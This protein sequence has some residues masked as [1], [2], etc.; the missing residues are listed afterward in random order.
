MSREPLVIAVDLGGTRIRAALSNLEG[1]F[2]RRLEWSTEAER[3]RDAALERIVALIQEV[4]GD[5][6]HGELL[7]VGVGTPGPLD[8]R[9]GLVLSAPNM[10]GWNDLPLRT[11]LEQQIGLPVRLVNDANGAVLGEWLFGAGRGRQNLIYVT[12]STG[13]GGGVITDGHLL[14]GHCGLAGE[15]G[16]MTLQADGPRCNCGNYGCWEALASGTAIAR[17]GAAAARD[18]RSPLLAELCQGQPEQVDARMVGQAARQGDPVA[19]QIVKQAA[20]YCGVGLVNLLHLYSPEIILVGGGVSKMGD[21]LFQPMCRI[22]RKQAMPAYRGVP[23]EPAS[24]G[25]DMGLLG[26]VA[27]FRLEE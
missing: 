16:H 6:P 14:L 11:I 3:G 19:G 17:E 9:A 27:L 13:I 4:R 2:L 18:G 5:V 15:V 8:P 20:R 23:I 10:P 22:A 25:E 26:A 24:L 21:L 12:I 1:H 7:G